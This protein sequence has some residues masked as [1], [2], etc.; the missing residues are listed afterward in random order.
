M[1]YKN[2]FKSVA[3]SY[4]LIFIPLALLVLVKGLTGRY[5]DILLTGDWSIASAMMYSSSLFTVWNATSNYEGDINRS[6]INW[7]M[8]KTVLMSS[9]NIGIY[10]ISLV[11]PNYK[12]GIVQILFFIIA[13]VSHIKS[14]RFAYRINNG[15][16]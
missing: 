12:I 6:E 11:E 8:S 5:E 1:K 10:V 4:L 13:S 15:D 14:G 2:E 16:S 3:S 7:F 9:S